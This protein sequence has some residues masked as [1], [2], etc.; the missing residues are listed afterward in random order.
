MNISR[1]ENG[2]T[3]VEL[4]IAMTISLT[5]IF[6]CVSVYSSLKGSISVSQ[7][8]ASAQDSLRTA[9]YLMSRAIRQGDGLAISGAGA[10]QSI[11]VTYGAQ[12]T[13]ND[14]RGCLGKVQVDTGTDAFY[15]GVKDQTSYLYCKSTIPNSTGSVVFDQPIALNVT[16]LSGALATNARKGVEVLL[17]IEGM[18]GTTAGTLGYDGIAFSIAMHQRILVDSNVSGASATSL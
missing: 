14:F 12:A 9:H 2:F 16:Y 5:L 15:I 6:A 18:P 10:T 7:N 1:T 3:I 4:L 8:L 13:G 17:K 11:V